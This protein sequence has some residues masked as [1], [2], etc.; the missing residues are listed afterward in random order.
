MTLHAAHSR[1]A[2]AKAAGGWSEYA[3]LTLLAAAAVACLLASVAATGSGVAAAVAASVAGVGVAVIAGARLWR[4]AAGDDARRS[5]EA[6]LTQ[7]L[8]GCPE[9]YL[10]TSEAGFPIYANAAYRALAG[11]VGD[12]VPPTLDE[13][14][15]GDKAGENILGRVRG[16]VA[17]GEAAREELGVRGP[18]GK[19][20]W[21]G[22][23]AHALDQDSGSIVWHVTDDTVQHEIQQVMRGEQ[24]KLA[25]FLDKAP[26]GFYSVDADGRFVFVNSTLAGWL[27]YTPEEMTGAALGLAD[28][29]P[30]GEEYD[31]GLAAVD[32]AEGT[33]HM[34]IRLCGR[35]GKPIPLF[36]SQS[37]ARGPGGETQTRS[38]VLNLTQE[39]EW[40]AALREAEERFRRFFD[41]AP[42][43]IVLID[44]VGH[45]VE[46][47]AA[48]YALV[49]AEL[50]VRDDVALGSFIDEDDCAEVLARMSPDAAPGDANRPLEVHLKGTRE[51]VAQLYINRLEDTRRGAPRFILHLIDASEQKK[52]ELQ[53]AQ[54]QKMQAVGQLAGG[55]AH[56][57]NNLLTSMI[58][59]CD[60]LLIRHQVGDQSFADIMQIKQNANRA[61]NLVRQLLAFSRQQT[62]QPKV[63]SIT[64]VLAELS[65]LLRRLIGENIELRMVHGRDLGLVKVDQGQF[66]QVII[67]LAVN[68]RDAMGTG[69][70]LTIRTGNHTGTD[71]SRLAQA[72]MP[73]GDYVLVEVLDTGRGIAE[74]DMGK[75]F[76]P[77]FT[78]KE[79]GAGTGLGLA[80]VYG[81]V[82]QTGGFIFPRSELG[83]GASFRIYLPRHGAPEAVVEVVEEGIREPEADLTGKGTILLVEDED[84]VR[85]FAARVLR[86]KGYEVLEAESGEAALEL[87]AGQEGAFDLLISDVVM[88]RMDGPTLLRHFR[89]EDPD[90]KVILISGYAE[91]ALRKNLGDTERINFLPKPFSLKQLAGKVKDVM[92]PTAA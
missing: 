30:E 66:E 68:A 50:A 18:E 69:G 37:L 22:L 29:M 14:V 58:G 53:F 41:H 23:W 15:A 36:V 32:G 47:N 26:I 77:F 21:L 67:N 57:F 9:G 70:K 20:R 75:I 40:E 79:V 92:T 78:T 5:I 76:E 13:L 72:I 91:D 45:V 61:A 83:Q 25:D 81:I 42:V 16:R 60:L 59:F 46:G 87:V 55:I 74:E 35:D 65:N 84:A 17:A 51:R 71:D 31:L 54:S 63:L 33:Q 28:V 85:I 80:T 90:L 43:G 49:D 27:G 19:Q 64:D 48:F 11:A 1:E 89:Q 34:E 8:E 4:S 7:A 73:A 12:D 24:Q 10:V 88:P 2:A 38:A 52:L 56:D 3:P 86:N 6:I 39:H 44:D 62:L 82:K